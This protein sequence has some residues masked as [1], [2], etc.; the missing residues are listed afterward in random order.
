M[1]AVFHIIGESG[2]K[3]KGGPEFRFAMGGDLWYNEWS[4]KNEPAA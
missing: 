2:A 3:V 1:S 4:K